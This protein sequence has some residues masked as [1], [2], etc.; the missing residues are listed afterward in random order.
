MGKPVVNS[1]RNGGGQQLGM[2]RPNKGK[3]SKGKPKNNQNLTRELATSQLVSMFQDR[4]DP[5]VVCDRIRKVLNF[6][7]NDKPHTYES[8]GLKN[9]VSKDG[10]KINGELTHK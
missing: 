5:K 9:Y 1:N 3:R 8:F 7:N 6:Y 2:R 10:P 4:C